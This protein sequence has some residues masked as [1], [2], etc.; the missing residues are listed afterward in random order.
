MHTTITAANSA[1]SGQGSAASSKGLGALS[2]LLLDGK[3]LG[4]TKEGRSMT[5]KIQS[6]RL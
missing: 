2:V 6:L 1:K 4:S 5:G 3:A